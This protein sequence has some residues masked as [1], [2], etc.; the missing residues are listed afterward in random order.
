MIFFSH[1]LRPHD[2][3]VADPLQLRL[4]EL[5]RIDPGGDD[6]ARRVVL[7]PGGVQRGDDIAGG[8]SGAMAVLVPDA[9]GIAAHAALGLEAKRRRRRQRE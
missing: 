7:A 2:P 3:P 9:G 5:S 1:L 6:D 8:A 4:Q